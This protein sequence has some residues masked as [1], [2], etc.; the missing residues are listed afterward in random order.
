MRYIGKRT[1]LSAEEIT[2]VNQLKAYFTFGGNKVWHRLV[3]DP[4][5]KDALI[6]L[7]DTIC[8]GNEEIIVSIWEKH[9]FIAPWLIQPRAEEICGVK[10][11]FEEKIL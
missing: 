1:L 7:V 2:K 9:F 10:K 4:Y 3:W 6:F 5:K 8:K 11:L